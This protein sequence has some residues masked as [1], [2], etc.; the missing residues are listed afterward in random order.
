MPEEQDARRLVA[1]WLLRQGVLSVGEIGQELK[2]S[3]QTVRYWAESAGFD[4]R[5]Q[6]QDFKRRWLARALR[7]GRNR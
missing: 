1:L 5:K 6:R 3:R 4:W 7:N 2:V